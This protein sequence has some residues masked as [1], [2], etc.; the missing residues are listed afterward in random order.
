MNDSSTSPLE[1]ILRQCAATAPEP[2]YPKS[3]AIATGVSRDRLDP[4]LERLRM[5]GL[6]RLTDWVQGH[7]QGYVLTPDGERVLRNPRE[8]ARL[9]AGELPTPRAERDDPAP[10]PRGMTHY[11]RGEAVREALLGSF[12]PRATFLLV[13][14]NVGVFL[15][16]AMMAQQAGVLHNYLSGGSP[17]IAHQLGA[18]QPL[19][20]W[21]NHQWWR[22]ITSGFVH[23]GVL[24]ILL[25]MVN[26]YMLGPMLERMFGSVR[27]LILYF[28][29][30]MVG[31]TAM[32]LSLHP[33]GIGAGASGSIWGLMTAM[34]AWVLCNRAYLPREL[35]SAWLRQL[36]S[37]LLLNLLISFMPG[38][39]AAGHFGGGAAG[40]VAGFLL[41]YHRFGRIFLLRILALALVLFTPAAIVY[42]LPQAR[43]MAQD[44][45]RGNVLGQHVVAGRDAD[46]WKD[47]RLEPAR[48]LQRAA[49]QLFD[50]N[51]A[52]VLGKHA[53]RR[54][55]GELREA[56]DSL[57]AAI[58]NLEQALR[59]V[60]TAGPYGTEKVEEQRQAALESLATQRS[61]LFEVERCLEQGEAW[62]DKQERELQDLARASMRAR[63]RFTEIFNWVPD[64][65]R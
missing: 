6:V 49:W 50:D 59:V 31:S 23:F 14:A 45:R 5:A 39:S 51:V 63:A 2:W 32:V 56:R 8:V 1:L 9:Q 47:E 38:I 13:L 11:E 41:N 15:V 30:G 4:P 18:I 58:G 33:L 36:G 17:R 22:L 19:D 35:V 27:F 55:A 48:K 12:T 37:A 42:G 54:T 16:G 53:K 29:A 20:L 24:H 28:V 52:P 21:A 44:W 46:D 10:R 57:A 3:Y 40:F 34:V 61:F 62:T 26:L 25:N 64:R 7:G 65:E 60:S 43:R